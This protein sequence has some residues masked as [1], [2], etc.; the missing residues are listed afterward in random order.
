MPGAIGDAGGVDLNSASQEE[1][2][3]V[4]GLGRERAKRIID[5]RPLRSW[6]DVKKISG[7]SDKLVEDLQQAG[8]RISGES[9]KRAA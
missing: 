9:G 4:G 6:D 5:A 3:E 8:A 2:E 7:F 1:L